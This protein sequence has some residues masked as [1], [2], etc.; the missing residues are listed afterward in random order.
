MERRV[1]SSF[2]LHLSPPISLPWLSLSTTTTTYCCHQP[3]SSLSPTK[4]YRHRVHYHLL[5]VIRPEYLVTNFNHRICFTIIPPLSLLSQEDNPI[6]PFPTLSRHSLSNI[7]DLNAPFSYL[8]TNSQMPM[9]LSL[10]KSTNPILSLPHT[11][12]VY[13]HLRH[14]LIHLCFDVFKGISLST[15]PQASVPFPLSKA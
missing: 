1:W 14:V 9:Y 13:H 15:I 5:L 2:L 4:G 8:C 6:F 12:H 7:S 10:A 3:W 11:I